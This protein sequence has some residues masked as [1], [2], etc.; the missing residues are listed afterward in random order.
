MLFV[1]N[2]GL[3]VMAR[4]LL[5][6]LSIS[7]TDVTMAEITVICLKVDIVIPV[8]TFTLSSFNSNSEQVHNSNTIIWEPNSNVTNENV[9]SYPRYNES[10]FVQML[11]M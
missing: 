5:L 7:A 3:Y 4:H 2:S 8:I 1:L 10:M 11:Y 9:F 6:V